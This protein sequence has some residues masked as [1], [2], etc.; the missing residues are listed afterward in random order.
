MRY[1]KG[2]IFTL[3]ILMCIYLVVAILYID[4][5]IDIDLLVQEFHDQEFHD[6]NKSPSHTKIIN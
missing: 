1:Q 6:P 5:K 2:A 3:I 4:H